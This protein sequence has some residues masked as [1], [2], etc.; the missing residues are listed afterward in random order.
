MCASLLGYRCLDVVGTGTL[1]GLRAFKFP[2]GAS[3][4]NL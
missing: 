4:L 3:F 2:V 1:E